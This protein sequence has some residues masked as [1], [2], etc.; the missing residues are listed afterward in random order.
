MRS[1]KRKG[2]NEKQECFYIFYL[3]SYSSLPPYLLSVPGDLDVVRII[4]AFDVAG[5]NKS[6]LGVRSNIGG[7][8]KRFWDLA[9]IAAVYVVGLK[10][11][12]RPSTVA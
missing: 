4:P 11:S 10:G 6:N 7:D 5:T 9:G 2:K 8:V 3:T 1:E 12:P